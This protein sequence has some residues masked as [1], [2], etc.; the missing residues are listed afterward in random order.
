MPLRLRSARQSEAGQM[1]MGDEESGFL[2]RAA[3]ALERLEQRV[4][5]LAF[6]MHSQATIQS[7][8]WLII[9]RYIECFAMVHK[10]T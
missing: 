7:G 6:R 10:P 2:R 9:E 1:S 8:P 5:Y 3:E 4:D